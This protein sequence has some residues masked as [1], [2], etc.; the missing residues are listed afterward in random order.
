MP[1]GTLTNVDRNGNVD[2]KRPGGAWREDSPDGT[3]R[4]TWSD[5]TETFWKPDGTVAVTSGDGK[6]L[7]TTD[8]VRSVPF[9]IDNK[10]GTKATGAADGTISVQLG[11][12]GVTYRVERDGTMIREDSSSGGANHGV[13]RI[14]RPDRSLVIGFADG[15][16]STRSFNGDFY[17]GFPNQRI[18][19]IRQRDGLIKMG[20]TA[21]GSDGTEWTGTMVRVGEG[22]VLFT[23]FD[24]QG[25]SQGTVQVTP[26]PKTDIG[27]GKTSFRR[28]EK[29]DV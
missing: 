3:I 2:I 24:A 19:I 16:Y 25:I 27:K 12:S 7:I 4:V 29:G 20:I 21:P 28:L 17:M 26:D 9:T 23:L 10:D 11:D 14:E 15:S 18:Q 6:R 8:N 22:D 1:D 13:M 5:G